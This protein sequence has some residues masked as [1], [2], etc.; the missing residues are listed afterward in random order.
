[1]NID[2]LNFNNL[3]LHLSSILNF[4]LSNMNENVAKASWRIKA[5]LI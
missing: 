3:T 1:M 4:I 5:L 2:L